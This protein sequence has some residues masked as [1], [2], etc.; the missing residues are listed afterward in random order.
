[1]THIIDIAHNLAS[2]LPEQA[3][4]FL[5]RLTFVDLLLAAWGWLTAT[6]CGYMLSF[7][8]GVVTY[9][10]I[11]EGLLAVMRQWHG[12]IEQQYN[13]IDNVVRIM[14]AHPAWP[15]P[16]EAFPAL[17]A[18]HDELRL[19]IDKCGTP[20]G[21]TVDRNHRDATLKSA[22]GIC[23]MDIKIWSYD[24]CLHK[25]FDAAT[26]H[27]LGFLLPDE[28]GRH[29][30]RVE[31]ID[32]TAETKVK[33]ISADIIRVV[34]DQSA[35]ENA[36]LVTRGWPRGVTHVLI[37]IT[38]DDGETVVHSEISSRKYTDVK[39]PE[40]SRGK[41]FMAKASFLKHT[42]D[43]PRFGNEATFTMP[44]ETSDLARLHDQQHHDELEAR[45]REVERQRLEIERLMEELKKKK[46]E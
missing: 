33:V 1:M 8:A 17:C 42:N 23:L 27:D 31:P 29:H 38:A 41:Q 18:Y 6:G 28:H 19:L 12:T 20:A 45:T 10:D 39:M 44:Y 36:A 25:V 40:G 34:T 32:V 4:A 5:T 15:V 9:D 46:G 14:K 24:M 11:P 30:G 35:G 13:N 37:V 3:L 22:V 2:L 16:A 43:E 21:S 7:A 26:V